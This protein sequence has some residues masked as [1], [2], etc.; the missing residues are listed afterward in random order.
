MTGVNFDKLLGERLVSNRQIAPSDLERAMA[1]QRRSP[2]SPLGEILIAMNLVSR[3][4]LTLAFLQVYAQ[5]N[6]SDSQRIRWG[7]G[8]K[9]AGLEADAVQP[10][11]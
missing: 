11:A 2:D 5:V 6:A 8:L 7:R 9:R 10:I 3:E 4:A 1:T